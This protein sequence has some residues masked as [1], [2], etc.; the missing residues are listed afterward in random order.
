M[1]A[2]FERFFY[3]AHLKNLAS[4]R[5]SGLLSHN[6]MIARGI[7]HVDIADPGAQR[8]RDRP[9]PVFGRSIHDYVPLYI[10]PRN[11]MLYRRREWHR[12]LTII[13][14]SASIIQ[15][16]SHVYT[17]GNAASKTT[18]FASNRTVVEK[19][20]PALTSNSW[21]DFPDGKRQMCAEVLVFPSVQSMYLEGAICSNA[22]TAREVR[23]I[24]NLVSVI[25]PQMFFQKKP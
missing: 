16:Y 3:I 22:E 24:C 1:K 7:I 13:K 20:I 8:W 9:E 21:A 12:E 5:A 23:K 17:D 11:P 18:A 14:I 2:L 10:N 4:I 15:A 6:A 19:S 25:D